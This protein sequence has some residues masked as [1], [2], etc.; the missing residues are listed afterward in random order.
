M[1]TFLEQ[2]MKRLKAQ[3]PWWRVAMCFQT[4]ILTDPRWGW[5]NRISSAGWRQELITQVRHHQSGLPPLTGELTSPAEG[6]GDLAVQAQHVGNGRKAPLLEMAEDV[7]QMWC[8]RT[9]PLASPSD[10]VR[11]LS[12]SRW[13]IFRSR[14]KKKVPLKANLIKVNINCCKVQW[15][16]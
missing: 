15:S 13:N 1:Y 16:Q 7:S 6:A 4:V 9:W 11:E 3:L 8:S 2:F 12:S 14:G 10:S 5:L